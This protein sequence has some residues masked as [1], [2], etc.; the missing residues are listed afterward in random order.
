MNQL[1]KMGGDERFDHRLLSSLNQNIP[2]NIQQL[3][4]IKKNVYLAKINNEFRQ[5]KLQILDVTL[6]L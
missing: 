1:N 5:T 2:L 4:H 6:V 3:K